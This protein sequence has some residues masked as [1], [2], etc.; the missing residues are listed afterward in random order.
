MAPFLIARDSNTYS[1]C[2]NQI[3]ADQAGS[4]CDRKL[5]SGSRPKPMLIAGSAAMHRVPPSVDKTRCDCQHHEQGKPAAGRVEE[6][7]GVAFP[8]RQYH[9][10]Q[11]KKASNG[12]TSQG[13]PQGRAKPEGEQ[14]GEAKKESGGE[15]GRPHI[16][17]SDPT[18]A[19]P[20]CG[21]GAVAQS[22]REHN[23]A[24]KG[25]ENKKQQSEKDDRHPLRLAR[26][27]VGLAL[28]REQR[29]E[30]SA[31]DHAVAINFSVAK[32]VS[33]TPRTKIIP[34]LWRFRRCSG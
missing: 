28:N 9:T 23:H 25:E 34:K 24:D 29:S 5:G 8:P 6:S 13:K 16:H 14:E 10:E 4:D 31:R 12:H 18:P 32:R 17:G 33:W 15:T 3:V 1:D 26:V 2:V 30:V 19:L 21:A 27:R 22:K 7:L 11:P 20:P